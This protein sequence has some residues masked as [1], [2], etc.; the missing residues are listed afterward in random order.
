MRPTGMARRHGAA[1][2]SASQHAFEESAELVTHGGTAGASGASE[3][4]LHAL[5]DVGIDNT[6]MLTL[7]NLVL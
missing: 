3:K 6:L 4:R 2:R 5:P 1:A 7:M